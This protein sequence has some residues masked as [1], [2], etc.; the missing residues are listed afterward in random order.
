MS[1]TILV[2]LD[3]SDLAAGA[4]EPAAEIAGLASGRIHL[5]RVPDLPVHAILDQL[6]GDIARETEA[7]RTEAE[8]SLAEAARLLTARGLAVSTSIEEGPPAHGIARA[9][10]DTG[11]TLV[12]L[13]SHGRGAVARAW[14]G[15]TADRLIRTLD[16]PM[17]LLRKGEWR[18]PKR[19][20][21]G[22][23][24]SERAEEILAP[25]I[26]LARLWESGLLLVH[27]VPA[28]S[29]KSTGEAGTWLQHQSLVAHRYIH[30]LALKYR[31]QGFDVHAQVPVRWDP[32]QV[33]QELAA[34]D[35]VELLALATRGLGGADR[36]LLGSVADKVIRGAEL[37]T[38]VFRPRTEGSSTSRAFR[39]A[40][41][42]PVRGDE[43]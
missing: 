23:D 24:G 39:E 33:L 36:L 28:P 11:A 2:P 40:A 21:I 27:V 14:L 31:A 43:S 7:A 4:L 20:L 1:D 38:L 42:T 15:S 6:P 10:A 17:L 16:V 13:T 35:D 5:V 29:P 25:A 30:S 32:A 18:K 26:E 3:G 19:V 41:V 34:T 22:L 12:V 9:V 37:P 8:A